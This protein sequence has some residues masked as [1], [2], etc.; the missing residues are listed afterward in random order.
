MSIEIGIA[1]NMKIDLVGRVMF[2]VLILSMH[3]KSF[4]FLVFSSI[5]SEV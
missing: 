3:G 1:L 4:H 5:S 2:I